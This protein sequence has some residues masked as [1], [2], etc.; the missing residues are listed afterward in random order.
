MWR[1][2]AGIVAGLSLY[3]GKWKFLRPILPCLA[4]VE[5]KLTRFPATLA[6]EHFVQQEIRFAPLAAHSQKLRSISFDLSR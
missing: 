5:F 3:S 4:F 6:S 1:V 2:F